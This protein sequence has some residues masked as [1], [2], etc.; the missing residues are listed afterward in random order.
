MRRKTDRLDSRWRRSHEGSD[1]ARPAEER[2]SVISGI[3]EEHARSL[4]AESGSSLRGSASTRRAKT[5]QA[6][7]TPP[8]RDHSWEKKTAAEQ[9]SR[10]CGEEGLSLLQETNQ[11]GR[12]HCKPLQEPAS[13]RLR[14]MLCPGSCD[15]RSCDPVPTLLEAAEARG[16]PETLRLTPRSGLESATRDKAKHR[17]RSATRSA[18]RREGRKCAE[19]VN[20]PAT[21]LALIRRALHREVR[22]TCSPYCLPEHDNHLAQNSGEVCVGGGRR[23]V[24]VPTCCLVIACH[25]QES[26]YLGRSGVLHSAGCSNG[27]GKADRSPNGRLARRRFR[28]LPRYLTPP[29]HP[30]LG[31]EHSPWQDPKGI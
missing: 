4:L 11:C 3:S 21:P 13:E 19:S 17:G 28:F 5:R 24:S 31:P 7:Q 14:P 27:V 30:V 16:C 25:S 12:E 8:W 15:L 26:V 1:T 22:G 2:C 10:H 20:T 9:R 23:T 6:C 18:L 29:P